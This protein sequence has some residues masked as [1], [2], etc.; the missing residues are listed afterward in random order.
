MPRI[1]AGVQSSWSAARGIDARRTA[2]TPAAVLLDPALSAAWATPARLDGGLHAAWGL[3][4]Q[5]DS[6]AHATWLPYSVQAARPE[7]PPGPAA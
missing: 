1:A 6:A 2:A 5:M 3:A 4:A 7:D